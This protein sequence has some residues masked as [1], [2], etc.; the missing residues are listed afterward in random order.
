M[1]RR[2]LVAVLLVIG[3]GLVGYF[4]LE[5]GPSESHDTTPDRGPKV[6]RP[7]TPATPATIEISS[8]VLA[9]TDSTAQFGVIEVV[10]LDEFG[11]GVTGRITLEGPGLEAQVERESKEERFSELTPGSYRVRA[12]LSGEESSEQRVD[13]AA[14]QELR[15]QFTFSTL[16]QVR[17]LSRQFR[18]AMGHKPPRSIT[19]KGRVQIAGE[20]IT[21]EIG[22]AFVHGDGHSELSIGNDGSFWIDGIP[23]DTEYVDLWCAHSTRGRMYEGRIRWKPQ[24]SAGES[25][26]EFREE[27]LLLE[28]EPTSE[29]SLQG[30]VVSPSGDW[31]GG[32]ARLRFARGFERFDTIGHGGF[33]FEALPAGVAT[34]EA[35]TTLG[36]V[37]T[38]IE[39]PVAEPVELTVEDQR[40]A[41][42]LRIRGAPSELRSVRLGKGEA[43]ELA[44]ATGDLIRVL[45]PRSAR[46]LMLSSHDLVLDGRTEW[47]VQI[48]IEPWAAEESHRVMT[49]PIQHFY[50]HV[51][52]PDGTPKV[53]MS[54][55]D[56]AFGIDVGST[57]SSGNLAW[58]GLPTDISVSDY[59]VIPP[60]YL[61][62]SPR[63]S[64]YE[65][66]VD[67]GWEVVTTVATSEGS[68][69][70][71]SVSY[72]DG[73]DGEYGESPYLSNYVD[74]E[75]TYLRFEDSDSGWAWIQKVHLQPGR[76]VDVRL[77]PLSARI[78]VADRSPS[79]VRYTVVVRVTDGLWATR[80]EY[81]KEGLIPSPP[82]DVIV[83]SL[84][85]SHTEILGS[86][87]TLRTNDEMVVPAGLTGARVGSIVVHRP[88]GDVRSWIAR[89]WITPVGWNPEAFI[90]EESGPFFVHPVSE[91]R[92]VAGKYDMT[93]LPESIEAVRPTS[94]RVQVA[95]GQYVPVR[96]PRVP[97][98]SQ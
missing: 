98:R 5:L 68:P 37:R 11:V 33:S 83:Y 20:P 28:L 19:L 35:E 64:K 87:E 25:G 30:R 80:L 12:G 10:L 65:V 46:S 2:T 82:G 34:I 63:Q 91:F 85:S 48:S 62:L 3:I 95:P 4:H 14:S 50:L 53:D 72:G 75:S 42:D 92:V 39:L 97:A 31:V 41:L 60:Q 59:G 7:A 94:S 49:V 79:E 40:V 76:P 93:V 9:E 55:F 51:R 6:A 8:Q 44:P 22:K 58:Y 96:I 1:S 77:P 17:A 73:T 56:V 15:V 78:L 67:P 84:R 36:T 54:V 47:T 89:G 27:F 13:L 57:D 90:G 52:D 21:R 70:W 66:V 88:V 24:S 69:A 26:S 18:E 61:A 71:G 29:F 32:V 74:S 45:V 38:E 16:D 23:S 81:G 86:P 43:V